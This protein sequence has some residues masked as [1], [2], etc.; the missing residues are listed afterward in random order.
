MQI[1]QRLYFKE[2][3]S[4]VCRDL[5]SPS[6]EEGGFSLVGWGFLNPF[7]DRIGIFFVFAAFQ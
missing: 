2:N 7:K 1:S 3:Q 5:L 6:A 4:Y